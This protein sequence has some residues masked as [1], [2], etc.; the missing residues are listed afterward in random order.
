VTNQ[1]EWANQLNAH[2][3]PNGSSRRITFIGVGNP[4]KSDDAVG[5][6]MIS[7][8]RKKCGTNPRKFV[9]IEPVSSSEVAFSKVGR[10]AE[11]GNNE[12]F[13]VFD[14]VESN[15]SAGSIIFASIGETKYGFFA[16]H[17]VPLKLIPG[18]ATNASNIF[19][20][21][22]QTVNT[23]IGETLSDIVRDSADK[24]VDK[25]GELIKNTR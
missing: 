1:E 16:T 23:D 20:L 14:A 25:I 5:L 13:I 11:R 12:T 22:V 24:I 3:R 7:Q 17:N 10:R 6:Y 15:V 2:I 4:I 9:R 21:G 8:L 19:I 18:L